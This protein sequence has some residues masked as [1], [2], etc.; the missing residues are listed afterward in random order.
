MLED[1]IEERIR[2]APPPGC[3]IVAGSTP[4]V[5]FGNAR[6][7]RV[8]T[9]GLNPSKIEFL[10]NDG[11]ELVG[12]RRR[13]ASLNSLG[14][15][16]LVD[17]SREQVATVLH[18]CER[19]FERQPY[20]W[21]FD[22]LEAVLAAI[23]AS[24]YG[25]R[26]TACHLDIV[27]WATDPTWSALD[28]PARAKLVAAD[29]PFLMQQL[30]HSSIKLLLVNGAGP[31][32]ELGRLAGVEFEPQGRLLAVGGIVGKLLSGTIGTVRVIGWRANLQ[33]SHGVANVERRA[34]GEAVLAV[35][36]RC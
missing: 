35:V 33:S 24:Y 13:L 4:V 27:Q 18:D 11:V 6:T 25:D 23:G 10:E 19:Y 9:L 20:R 8:A 17:A 29:G 36:G 2:R 26:P 28:R 32:H 30:R 31:L 15:R 5:S 1:W 7:A 3:C 14:V 16:S 12:E 34:L 22:Q 21:W